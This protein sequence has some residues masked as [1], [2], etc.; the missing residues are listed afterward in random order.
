MLI[1]IALP[2]RRALGIV[3]LFDP[4]GDGGFVCPDDRGEGRWG[5]ARCARTRGASWGT[6]CCA[7]TLGR[8]FFE[9]SQQSLLPGGIRRVEGQPV[10]VLAG[11]GKRAQVGQ[12]AL[13]DALGQG[14]VAQH[15]LSAF[16]ADRCQAGAFCQQLYLDLVQQVAHGFG[17]LAKAVCKFTLQL[18]HTGGVIQI[19]H[20]AVELETHAHIGH[21]TFGDLDRQR[22]IHLHWQANLLLEQRGGGFRIG[23]AAQVA[24]HLHRRS[25]QAGV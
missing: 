1:I 17:R 14:R 21:V 3:D 8:D 19:C 18:I 11:A 15:D 12:V 20:A 16:G 7:R 2:D 10:G 24:L 23:H 25:Q 22:Q 6:A 13:G 5:A 9:H 4:F